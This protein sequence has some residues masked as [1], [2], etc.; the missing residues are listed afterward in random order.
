M[1]LTA[2]LRAHCM[3]SDDFNPKFSSYGKLGLY[4]I[5]DHPAWLSQ[6]PTNFAVV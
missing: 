4:Q 2:V 5:D 1:S 3:F 6:K